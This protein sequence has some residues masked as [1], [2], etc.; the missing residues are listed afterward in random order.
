MNLY[1]SK[2]LSPN[3]GTGLPDGRWQ[4]VAC[5]SNVGVSKDLYEKYK[6]YLIGVGYDLQY[7]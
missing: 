2:G 6:A 4:T 3:R 1:G 7:K 5:P